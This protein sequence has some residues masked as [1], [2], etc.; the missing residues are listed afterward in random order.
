MLPRANRLTK[1]KDFE[2]VFKKGRS[3]KE[4]F[5]ILKILK[6]DSN[7]I[8]FG[9]IVSQRVSKKATVRNKI[10]R[11]I[12]KLVRQKLGKLKKGMDIVLITV[13]G[14]ETKDFWEMEESLSKLF[15]KSG[16]QSI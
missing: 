8:R 1:K 4:D 12:S 7:Q 6:D 3:F 5:L 15:K 9:F 10:K 16:I 2:G 11:R 13:P 14:I